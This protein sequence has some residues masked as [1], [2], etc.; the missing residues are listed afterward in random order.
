[1]FSP[2]CPE[3]LSQ[4]QNRVGGGAGGDVGGEHEGRAGLAAG[5]QPGQFGAGG[6]ADPHRRAAG[7]VRRGQPGRR[8]VGRDE[9]VVLVDD[10]LIG[11]AR[12]GADNP[13]HTRVARVQQRDGREDA[14][15]GGMRQRRGVGGVI[16]GGL[17]GALAGLVAAGGGLP[18]IQGEHRRGGPDQGDGVLGGRPER[19]GIPRA[20]G[21][22]CWRRVG[23]EVG[24]LGG[25]AVRRRLPRIGIVVGERDRA[26]GADGRGDAY[27]QRV[28]ACQPA[29]EG[30][31]V[32][33]HG[34]TGDAG[35]LAG[36]PVHV[37]GVAGASGVAGPE[38]DKLLLP[39]PDLVHAGQ[40]ATRMIMV[41][42]CHC[43]LLAMGWRPRYASGY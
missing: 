16:C 11:Q 23:A 39:L 13:Q 1:M 32:S 43:P 30:Q 25:D 3:P 26:G 31:P 10:L 41:T 5:G 21:S 8:R 6:V 22:G 4:P 2:V 24:Q 35:E 38:P 34:E 9:R 18:G 42:R 28:I 33:L 20:C 17:R 40:A 15:P 27:L 12:P 29:V 14:L 7:V 36:E 37:G 19:R